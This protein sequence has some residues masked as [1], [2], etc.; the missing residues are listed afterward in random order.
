MLAYNFVKE[1]VILVWR[2]FAPKA[3]VK[4]IHVIVTVAALLGYIAYEWYPYLA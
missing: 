1:H 3:D 2:V 4:D